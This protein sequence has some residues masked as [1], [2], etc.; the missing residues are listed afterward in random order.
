MIS[1]GL[2][3]QLHLPALDLTWNPVAVL[4]TKSLKQWLRMSSLPRGNG[5][6]SSLPELSLAGLVPFNAQ[7]S[8]GRLAIIPG[9]VYSCKAGG[10]LRAH[11]PNKTSLSGTLPVRW[12]G[13]DA[14]TSC[15]KLMQGV[16][17]RPTARPVPASWSICITS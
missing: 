2:R 16:R 6:T 15:R 12:W 8:T 14:V 9:A 4:V 10:F 3:V 13:K 11:A 7:D 5:F 1:S 17:F